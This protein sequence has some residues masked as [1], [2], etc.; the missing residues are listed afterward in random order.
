MTDK[1][2]TQKTID[3]LNFF[4]KI[5][6][7]IPYDNEIVSIQGMDEERKRDVARALLDRAMQEVK[8]PNKYIR[9]LKQMQYLDPRYLDDLEQVISTKDSGS[10]HNEEVSQMILQI[11]AS[12]PYGKTVNEPFFW[13]KVANLA[14]GTRDNTLLAPIINRIEQLK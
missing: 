12:E 13:Q 2:F 6:E 14:I 4:D 10:Q 3:I 5:E 7:N 9:A 11:S 8:I 1:E